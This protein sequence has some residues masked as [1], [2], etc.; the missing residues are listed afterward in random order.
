MKMNHRFWSSTTKENREILNMT[1]NEYG[2]FVFTLDGGEVWQFTPHQKIDV[3]EI[4]RIKLMG[5]GTDSKT[6]APS[7]ISFLVLKNPKESYTGNIRIFPT[8]PE[9]EPKNAA[10]PPAKRKAVSLKDAAKICGVSVPTIRNWE[11]GRGTPEGWTGRD[12]VLILTAFAGRM[13][14]GALLKK[15]VLGATRYGDIDK[16][17]HRVQNGGRR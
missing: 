2:D 7:L 16:V 13:A 5:R 8:T 9:K 17:S 1:K 3:L 6:K 15:A 10:K 12:D 14:E 4:E 11:A